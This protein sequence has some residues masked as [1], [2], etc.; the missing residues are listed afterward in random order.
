MSRIQLAWCGPYPNPHDKCWPKLFPH[1]D[2]NG[3]EEVVRI[4][5]ER[6]DANVNRTNTRGKTPLSL[7]TQNWHDGVMR[8][9]PGRNYISPSIADTKF[10][11]TPLLWAA[12]KAHAGA[13]RIP[14]ERN[15][16]NLETVDRYDQTP[17]C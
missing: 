8:I 15:D 17:L 10:S 9:Q 6:N 2:R 16:V 7:A 13:V 14:L 5:L 4:L 1:G 12:W 3:G 11:R